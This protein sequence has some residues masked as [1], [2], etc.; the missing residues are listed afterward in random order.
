MNQLDM[1]KKKE[2]SNPSTVIAE[3]DSPKKSKLKLAKR[4][5]IALDIKDMLQ[6][7]KNELKKNK[8]IEGALV[9]NK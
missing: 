6:F 8:Y 4:R 3:T 2:L 5:V 7:N 1:I 9:R